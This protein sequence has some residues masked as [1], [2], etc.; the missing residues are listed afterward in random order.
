MLN[1]NFFYS[2]VLLIFFIIPFQSVY[3]QEQC[4]RDAQ[5]SKPPE[6][7]K[8]KMNR[9]LIQGIYLGMS[10]KE[11]QLI[12]ENLTIRPVV[13]AGVTREFIG[14]LFT[15]DEKFLFILTSDARLYK[16]IYQKTFQSAV[17]EE[18]LLLRLTQRYGRPEVQLQSPARSKK[19]F[20]LCWG[21][22]DMIKDGVFCQNQD[23][24]AWYTYFTA[25]LDNTR[26]HFYLTLHDSV[27]FERNELIFL[28]KKRDKLNTNSTQSL[29]N[30]KL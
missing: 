9:Y 15:K 4:K 10:H 8:P 29:N 20:E 18:E 2:F 1:K 13:D 7:A 14:E 19:I 6:A 12:K 27:L 30:L 22:C 28:E 25:S 5:S 17:E 24:D 16:F 3:A 23:T 21:Q 26:K 11:L